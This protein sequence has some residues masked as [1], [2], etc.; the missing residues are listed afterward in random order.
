MSDAERSG[1][2]ATSK[3]L[4]GK[5]ALV[6]GGGTGLG[7]AIAVLFASEG[8]SVVIAGRR[9]DPLQDT[10]REIRASGGTA[11]FSKGDVSRGEMA[12]LIVNSAVYTFGG[13]DILVNSAAIF[14]P[15]T[16]ESTNERR[17]DRLM[18]ANLKGPYLVSRLA[19]PAMRERG[20]G[21]IVNISGAAGL[22]GQRD[23][24]AFA[25]TKGG[26]LA[27]TRSMA[28]DHAGDRIRINAI[29]PGVQGPP[30]AEGPVAVDVAELPG[31]AAALA[32][33]LASDEGS[34][35]TGCVFTNDF[36]AK[37]G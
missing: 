29:C 4:Q 15:G 16:V 13:L 11:S 19:V 26:L 22:E 2:G 27:M 25:A 31:D 1:A 7:R 10:V 34:G 23:A 28:L 18:G 5:T 24:V 35:V 36:G 32:L 30:R 20:G 6:T 21:C 12:E 3:R 8:A 37:A 9:S 33:F 17:W 14:L